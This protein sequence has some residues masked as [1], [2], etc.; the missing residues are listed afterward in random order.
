MP[1]SPSSFPGSTSEPVIRLKGV[2]TRIEGRVLHR[3][4]DLDLYPGEALGV[5][6]ASGEGKSVLLKTIVGL[7][8]PAAGA[9]EIFGRNVAQLNAEERE[10]LGAR[11]GVLFQD[12]ALF[13][14]LT[15]AE[16]IAVPLK[17]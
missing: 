15:V 9:I 11:W 6:G 8:P 16:N 17:E 4:I 2:A 12:G 1:P 5:V 10:R 14:S 13:S 3:N 7:V